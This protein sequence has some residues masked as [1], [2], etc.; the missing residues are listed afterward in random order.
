MAIQDNDGKWPLSYLRRSRLN[1]H[2]RKL[3]IA[4]VVNTISK[5]L[6]ISGNAADKHAI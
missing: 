4:Y 3:E 6:F 2:V 5:R 1:L